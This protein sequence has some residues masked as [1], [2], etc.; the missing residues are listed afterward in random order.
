MLPFGNE[1]RNANYTL[2]SEG[3]TT[4]SKRYDRE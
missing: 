1:N 4:A 2:D 3:Q